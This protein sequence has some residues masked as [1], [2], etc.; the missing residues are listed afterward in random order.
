MKPQRTAEQS[1]RSH[2]TD[3]DITNNYRMFQGLRLGLMQGDDMATPTTG[4][5]VVNR[6]AAFGPVSQNEHWLG[7]R[8]IIVKVQS[9]VLPRSRVSKSLICRAKSQ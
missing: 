3:I 4:Q 1:D 8:V 7:E 2:I 6:K 5:M 9:I